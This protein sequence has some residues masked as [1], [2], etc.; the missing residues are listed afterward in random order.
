MAGQ[1]EL[2]YQSI[3]EV[4]VR[5]SRVR[6]FPSRI[7]KWAEKSLDRLI[8]LEIKKEH[9]SDRGRRIEKGRKAMKNF[10]EDRK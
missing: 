1:I 10:F 2:P 4:V 7:K 6:R 5:R 3:G 9:L 8:K